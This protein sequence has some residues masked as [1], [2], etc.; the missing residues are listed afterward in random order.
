[1][2]CVYVIRS[3]DSDAYKIGWTARESY[4]VKRLHELQIGNPDPLGVVLVLPC[5]MPR[6]DRFVHRLFGPKRIHG[7]WFRLTATDLDALGRLRI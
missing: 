6:G 5:Q 1:V 3:G 2:G 7:E 4:P